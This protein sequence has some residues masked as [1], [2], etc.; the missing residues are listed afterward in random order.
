MNFREKKFFDNQAPTET[1]LAQDVS[2][3]VTQAI[4]QF[5]LFKYLNMPEKHS[6]VSQKKSLEALKRWEG[7]MRKFDDKLSQIYFGVFVCVQI[8]RK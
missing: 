5:I 7:R 1:N 4:S 3:S 8:S 6:P 2:K